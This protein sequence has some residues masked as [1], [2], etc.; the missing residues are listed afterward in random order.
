[1]LRRDPQRCCR[2]RECRRS[3]ARERPRYGH[4]EPSLDRVETPGKPPLTGRARRGVMSS[5]RQHLAVVDA[6]DG[7][8]EV[9]IQRRV[10]LGVE[11]S[12]V[13]AELH[14]VPAGGE[15]LEERTPT[16]R[17]RRQL[18][19]HARVQVGH[20]SPRYYRSD[21]GCGVPLAHATP[22][23]DSAMANNE[24]AGV[25]HLNRS[26][27]CSAYGVH[28]AHGRTD[29]RAV[30]AALERCQ[31]LLPSRAGPL[32]DLRGAFGP[33]QGKSRAFLLTYVRVPLCR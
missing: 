18:G 10:A 20:N 19:G 12:P 24:Y 6:S 33:P 30:Y 32:H 3:A 25:W 8:D 22:S 26:L 29:V 16:S 17:L 23:A 7:I 4:C 13:K 9:G 28:G 27:R 31:T 2:G 15:T 11:I 21:L 14:V 1:M 5:I